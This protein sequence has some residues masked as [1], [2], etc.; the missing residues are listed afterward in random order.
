MARPRRKILRLSDLECFRAV[1]RE[2]SHNSEFEDFDIDGAELVLKQ[3]KPPYVPKP[4]NLQKAI[5]R[6]S[7]YL[8]EQDATEPIELSKNQLSKV[9]RISR[10]T[11]DK[12]IKAGIIIEDVKFHTVCGKTLASVPF[13]TAQSVLGS[14]KAYNA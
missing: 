9:L 14:L 5:Y 3:C 11:L 4:E 7:A 8:S 10:P 13:L 12:W 2:L 1:R 6:L